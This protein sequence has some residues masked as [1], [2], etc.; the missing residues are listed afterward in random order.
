MTFTDLPCDHDK[1]NLVIMTF[2]GDLP[3]VTFTGDLPCE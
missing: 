1:V 2:T 3:C